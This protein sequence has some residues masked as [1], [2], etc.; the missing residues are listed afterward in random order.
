MSPGCE[1]G[2]S[3]LVCTYRTRVE[4]T[5]RKLVHTN[6]TLVHFYVVAGTV[7]K[8]SAHVATLKIEVILS[9]LHEARIQTS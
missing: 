3:P 4:G 5:V 9:L 2:T 1:A 7:C 6:R 8:R